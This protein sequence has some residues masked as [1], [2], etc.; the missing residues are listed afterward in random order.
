MTGLPRNSS[1]GDAKTRRSRRQGMMLAASASVLA[2]LAHMPARAA[3]T[4]QNGDTLNLNGATQNTD[5]LE[6]I[7]GSVVNGTLNASSAFNVRN[8]TI[9]A[10]LAGL[11]ELT[12]TTSGVVTLSSANS[13]SGTSNLFAGTLQ[14]LSSAALGTGRIR[15]TFGVL[16][17]S[18]GLNV[19]NEIE[20]RNTGLAIN[21]D[22]GTATWGGIISQETGVFGFEKTGAGNLRLTGANT[23]TGP[24][25]VS[26]G[27]LTIAG[28]GVFQSDTELVNGAFLTFVKTE[29]YTYNGVISGTGRVS[30]TN[31]PL[32]LT[33]AQTLTNSTFTVNP[34]A[35]LLLQPAATLG[36]GTNTVEL[37][38][39][40]GALTPALLDLGGTT[41]SI[42]RLDVSNVHNLVENGAL[43]VSDEIAISAGTIS[44]NLAGTAGLTKDSSN[45]TVTL[46]G[47]NAY[48]GATVINGGI[49]IAQGGSAIGDTSDVTIALDGTL[50][51]D[52]SET[53]GALSGAGAVNLQGNVLTTGRDGVNSSFSGLLAGTGALVKTGTGSLTLTGV[54]TFEGGT[55]L[56]GGTLRVEDSLALGGGQIVTSGASVLDYADGINLANPITLD[57]NFTQF[58]VL[59]G[60]ATQSGVISQDASD[61]PLEK[62][63]AGTLI[64]TAANTYS[65]L[66]TVSAGTL[67]LTGSGR[68]GNE[69]SSV[70]VESGATFDLTDTTQ[71]LTAL[72]L[73]G[74]A[75]VTGEVFGDFPNA[76]LNVDT[77]TATT[78]SGETAALDVAF[79]S[80]GT[81]TK[82]GLGTLRIG[83]F[84]NFGFTGTVEHNAG[85]LQLIWGDALGSGTV[86]MNGDTILSL[87]NGTGNGQNF[88]NQIN[89]T[90]AGAKIDVAENISVQHGEIFGAFGFEKTGFGLLGIAA[91]M[92]FT[93]LTKITEGGVQLREGLTG[94]Y[95]SLTGPIEIG[96]AGYLNL[97]RQ[98]T[99][100]D[101]TQT[102]S[103]AGGIGTDG[104][105]D[106][107]SGTVIAGKW[108]LSGNNTYSG[109]TTVSAGTLR[110]GSA[111][112][113]GTGFLN[114]NNSPINAPDSIA[115]ISLNG[116]DISA[117][118][119]LGNGVFDLG[120]NTLTVT[121][122]TGFVN[123]A[124]FTAGNLTVAGGASQSFGGVDLSSVVTLTV[125]GT[126]GLELTGNVAP[127]A[128]VIG[129]NGRLD[130]EFLDQAEYVAN[131]ISG[132][133]EIFLDD[134]RLTLGTGG[135]DVT[136]AS[137]VS[138]TGGSLKKTGA[139]ILTLSGTNTFDGG[140]E[141]AQGTLRLASNG[142]AGL[143]PITTTGSVI[144]YAAG[145][146]NPAPIVINSDTTQL[147]VLNGI[148]TQSGVI[149]ESGGSRPLE[150]I[151][152]G[153][154]I[155]TAANA[156]TGLT[157]VTN[158]RLQLGPGGSILGNVFVGPS[159]N[160]WFDFEQTANYTYNG[161]LSGGQVGITA[162]GATIE[163]T[164]ANTHSY[165][166]IGDGTLLL[167]GA[168]TLGATNAE[169]GLSGGTSAVLDL[170]GTTQTIGTLNT[171]AGW[172]QSVV[173]GTLN[174]NSL[175]RLEEGLFSANLG[176][177]GS[178]IKNTGAATILSGTNTFTGPTFVNGGT[179]VL[180]GGAALADTNAVTVNAGGTLQLDADET[181][182]LLNN[183]GDVARGANQL[184]LNGPLTNSGDTTGTDRILVVAQGAGDGITNS[185]RV[186]TT[187]ARTTIPVTALEISMP[188]D[189]VGDIVNQASG[190]IEAIDWAILINNLMPSQT[191]AP[192]VNFNGTF[193]NDGT[194]SGSFGA[195]VNEWNGDWVN[196]GTM[197]YR[198]QAG[199]CGSLC[200]G[201]VAILNVL[202]FNG[203]IVNT[204]T[205]QVVDQLAGGFG[206]ALNVGSG[207]GPWF[208]PNA[209]IINGDLRNSGTMDGSGGDGNAGWL[210][211]F[212]QWNGQILN[213][214]SGL[215][216]GP[217]NNQAI[218]M[219]G[220]RL[221]DGF[222]NRGTITGLSFMDIGSIDALF[223][224]SGTMAA[225][226]GA[227]PL[228]NAALDLR[229]GTLHSF[230]NTA[231]GSI[232]DQAG[233]AF[234]LRVDNVDYSVRN[235]GLIEAFGAGG[236]A[237]QISNR[238]G[239]G[240]F[241]GN[242]MNLGTM[243]ATDGGTAL[244]VQRS[245]GLGI[246][247]LGT[248]EG[249][250][251]LNLDTNVGFEFTNLGTLTGNV[252]AQNG[253]ADI[254]RFAGGSL[255]GNLLTDATDI[256]SVEGGNWNFGTQTLAHFRLW[257]G[258][259]TGGVISSNNILLYNGSV[260][261]VLDGSN[262]IVKSGTGTVTISG[263][264][265]YTGETTILNG[266]LVV[267]GGS[268]IDDFG[269]VDVA[270]GAILQLDSSETVG[271]VS[272]NGLLALGGSSLTT[273]GDNLPTVF[274]GTTTGSTDSQL[275]KTGTGLLT[276]END[277]GHLGQTVINGGEINF[278]SIAAG[279]F[280]VNAGGRLSGTHTISGNLT[281][282]S[283]GT[284]APG[285][286]PGTTTVL[287]DFT[288]GGILEVEV[289]FDNAG[290]PVNGVTH[291]FLNIAGNVLGSPTTVSLL[292]FP[293]SLEPA[294][295]TGNGIEIVRVG[296]AVDADDFTMT[297]YLFGD[298]F[299]DLQFIAAT[300]NS[301]Y[302]QSTLATPGCAVT[303]GNDAC[304]IDEAANIL[305][306]A[307][308]ALAGND[309]LQLTG[310]E[311]FTF[312]VARIGTTY[313]NFEVFQKA[314][315]NTVTLAGVA[316][317]NTL[318]FDV[319]NGTLIAG[320]NQLGSQG[321]VRL[322]TPGI[323]QVVSNLQ[324]GSLEGS[325][326]LDVQAGEFQ[327]GNSNAS[328]TFSGS[329]TGAGDFQKTGTGT[330][331]LS[332]TNTL[333]GYT[334]IIGG[335]LEVDGGAAINDL[336]RVILDPAGTFRLLSDETI[337][338]LE[339]TLVSGG[340]VDLGSHRL[341]LGGNN[342]GT[343]F[344]GVLS[345]TGGL[346]VIGS[347]FA[348]I[349]LGGINTFTGDTIIDGSQV[350]LAGTD[351][352][353][354]SN[355]QLLNGGRFSFQRTADY[356]YSGVISGNGTVRIASDA[357][358]VWTGANSFT[359]T[360]QMR[361]G[362][363][364][365]TSS[366]VLG[367][368]TLDVEFFGIEGP[369]FATLDLGGTSQT[370]GTLSMFGGLIEDGTL[371]FNTASLEE[372]E[373]SA[374]LAGSG[375][376]TKITGGLF[377]LSGTN[378]YTGPTNIQ[379]GTLVAQG[380]AAI[381]DLSAVTV[382]SG[383]TF[384]ILGNETVGSVNGAG[385]VN[386]G[387]NRLTLGGNNAS[388][389][390]S[391]VIAG[392]AGKLIKQGSGNLT[393]AGNNTFT[394]GID[395]FDGTLTL[396]SNQAAG[397]GPITTFGTV[398]NY[399]NLVNNAAPI[400]LSS[401]DTQLQQIGGTA[402]QSGPISE[403]GGS[404]PL[405]KIGNG[406]LTLSGVNTFTGPM[407]ISDGTLSLQGGAALD[408]SVAVI[409][410]S[411]GTLGLN[412]NETVGSIA[413]SGAI[414]MSAGT[415]L[416]AGGDNSSTLFSGTMTGGG[417]TKAGSGNFTFTGTGAF[418]GPLNVNA[419]TF[420][421]TGGGLSGASAFNVAS[422]ATAFLGATAAGVNGGGIAA[423]SMGAV[424]VAGGGTLYLDDNS[425]VTG[426]SLALTAGSNLGLFLTTNTSV[427]PQLTMSG[428]ASVA[429]TLGIYL[430]PLSFGGTTA[431]AFAYDNV[432]SGS[433][434]SGTFSSASL[435]QTPSSLFSLTTIYGAND[436]DLLVQRAS[437]ASI[438]G[439]AGNSSN[440]GGAIETIFVNGTSDPDLLNLISTLSFSSPGAI[441]ATLTSVSGSTSAETE[442]AGLR[443][444]DPWKQSVAERVNAARA[445][446]CVVA[447]DDWCFKRYAQAGGSTLSDIQGDPSAFEW[448]QTGI[449]DSDTTSVWARA[450]GIV[451]ETDV[452]DYAPGSKQWSGGMIVG[453]DHVFSSLLLAGLAA[454]Y[455]ETHVDFDASSNTSV[456]KALQLGAYVSHGDARSF[457]NGNVSV[458]GSQGKSERYMTVGM[459]SYETESF[460]RSWTG[461]ASVEAGTILEVDGFRFEPTVSLNYQYSGTGA[462]REQGGGGLGLLIDPDD[463]Q[464]LKS[465][466]TARLSRVFDLGDR[467][468]VPQLRA[469]WRHEFLDRG[470]SFTA[471]FAGAPGVL[472]D[473]AGTKYSRDTLG[474]GAS[475]TVPISGQMTGYVDS[476]GALS[477][478]SV[479][480]MITMGVRA[481]W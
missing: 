111:T 174:V 162:T 123:G 135:I 245:T 277:L 336:S 351:G 251:A 17:L 270:S 203:D 472:F 115:T 56:E 99:A 156:Y 375:T 181:A 240:T 207:S 276:L 304:F 105:F 266:T 348:G 100:L 309:T 414:L 305:G 160:A 139:G 437:F 473:V 40:P 451:T 379:E 453:A 264:N 280:V 293:P 444:D 331:T 346:T 446:G 198:S 77:V 65:G 344:S 445:T 390:L 416:T 288:G 161:I 184:T 33:A 246:Y 413:G 96:G 349:S 159:G 173:N 25:T 458:I 311:D 428:A 282:A 436:V 432:I 235:E 405:E 117:S 23:F 392:V 71:T 151:G 97:L 193:T 194:I 324:T 443:T 82:N 34:G 142:A 281:L 183:S 363:L 128:I 358:T 258:N 241:A 322:F 42:Q 400:V 6:L 232:T 68:A 478:D 350:I 242:L 212:D 52:F 420:T 452:S 333:S 231:S 389:T 313:T 87:N 263:A 45:N 385:S 471:A 7:D 113:F 51:I 307:I 69:G 404:R 220:N 476:Q 260:A 347:S 393:L 238:T 317:F 308:D 185:G 48:T 423:T 28:T 27:E 50:Q 186:E 434:R 138:G 70:T 303:T 190:E 176:G 208:I 44:A 330:L 360:L 268:A 382:S 147:Q 215:V 409:I 150:K 327:T 248:L 422:G 399:L 76:F 338:S 252:D 335:V 122:S 370:I 295:T 204:G 353:L 342:F 243:R 125:D 205:M 474:L 29:G 108:T 129:T 449:R 187:G 103:G 435:L 438:G 228:S 247:N 427:Y 118:A 164:G 447:G 179:L 419:G 43:I 146:N 454:Q 433:S 93:G 388:T 294:A 144:D 475:L 83:G 64:F 177:T 75:I 461:S 74:N 310:A 107:G 84:P 166:G 439:G 26:A 133:G 202:E 140:I 465:S 53:I 3:I 337:G 319:Q 19:F 79:A 381:G 61:R 403:T 217:V 86:N 80:G 290:A 168:G 101:L 39:G 62:T 373:I 234:W 149:S 94:V 209:T 343:F 199:S 175:M 366:A 431:T 30:A 153:N 334:S 18:T 357:A 120:G 63:G 233:T 131:A 328:T 262:G 67:R 11:G 112:A 442:G 95:G 421:K 468:I 227:A 412:T 297:S 284:L 124:S 163:W 480:S 479:S 59:A 395:I 141:L 15:T 398:I 5:T 332:G 456:V 14:L 429:G 191:P 167:S 172:T 13:Y 230:T 466:L 448:L 325:G 10:F 31:G 226:G 88:S 283:G 200:V 126:V 339:G 323:L 244:L 359:G 201:T 362:T 408:D 271:S 316:G 21:V 116:F 35:G 81:V 132:A 386:I 356:T 192:T 137:L 296:G 407:T 154:L 229:V 119:L 326:T 380:G 261:G 292:S 341:T 300:T 278:N 314:D 256:L 378:T 286:S 377:T 16:D 197:S 450:I 169:V 1:I 219:S 55:T 171:F 20:L 49:L 345:G 210:L 274:G 239:G 406:T 155:L 4:V 415:A 9:S 225:L 369:A 312:D 89:L 98:D 410:A 2:L 254:L 180:Q 72:T 218:G 459:L 250:T 222:V 462:Y 224:N 121:G 90:A 102:I 92:S 391:G 145:I 143:G 127:Q 355:V 12:K 136:L 469:D 418:G 73:N 467:K 463:T 273:G 287:G 464:S 374:N 477:S 367:A 291:D 85:T 269:A 401:N 329:I 211:A 384:S 298:Y 361:E 148:A 170:G 426:T 279:S 188:G 368:N 285:N 352:A 470:Q 24:A 189:W 182:G 134:S 237:M 104:I 306:T 265:T 114:T 195:W 8:G 364:A 41:Q 394:G 397:T 47:E 340:T 411:L 257:V 267:Q 425:Q 272:G 365:L 196:N 402:T 37:R 36:G 376:V 455:I 165:T 58:Q 321:A 236:V 106:F 417:F 214:T 221:R 46:S 320:T 301:F 66:T 430:D 441:V 152:T 249:A 387:A 91:P 396:G 383:A 372:G 32:T 481:T 315:T 223:E 109:G 255:S 253:G 460:L 299:Y 38:G 318:G 371:S 206:A 440:V 78:A 289:Q 302:L 216:A 157:T 158:G 259:L 110:A 275:I 22:A 457:V 60:S 57:T 213:E 178:L 424:G 130:L 54:N 354:A